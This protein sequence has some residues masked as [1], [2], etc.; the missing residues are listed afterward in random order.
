MNAQ[1]QMERARQHLQEGERLIIALRDMIG[2]QEAEGRST[3]AYE[4]LL[5]G[6]LNTLERMR[7][8]CQQD[9]IS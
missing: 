5:R 4:R 3:E 6:V 1:A 8:Y 7:T 2:E 9:R